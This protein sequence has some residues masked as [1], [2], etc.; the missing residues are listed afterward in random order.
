MAEGGIRDATLDIGHDGEWRIHQ[1]HAWRHGRIEMIVDLG[2]V[3]ARD[4]NGRK[5]RREKTAAHLAELVEHEGGAGDLGEDG[6]QAGAGR[7]LQHTVGRCDGG[8]ICRDQA[9]RDRGGELLEG[10]SFLGAARV[11]RKEAGDFRQSGKA[12]SRRRGFTEKRRSV[13]AQEE[14]GCGLAGLVCRFPVPSAGGVGCAEGAFHRGAQRGGVDALAAFKMG[15][16]Q[17]R[18]R[19]DGSGCVSVGGERKQRGGRS[20]G[21]WRNHVHEEDLGRAERD[22]ARAALSL[23]RTGSNPSRPSSGSRNGVG[24]RAA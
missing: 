19:E 4:G 15:E 21:E 17:A 7:R 16:Q 6:E 10:L 8:G 24:V 2:G 23:D 12:S 9:E 22:R 14:D 11:R 3:E 13:L 1:H 18:R 20:R 5:E